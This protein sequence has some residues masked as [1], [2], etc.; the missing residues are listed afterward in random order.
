MRSIILT[1]AFIISFPIILIAQ[2]HQ[3]RGTVTDKLTGE[4]LQYV[5]VYIEQLSRGTV[6]DEK[7]GF[8][9]VIP[10]G[11]Y[12]IT[13]G[14]IGYKSETADVERQD[15]ILNILMIPVSHFLNEVNIYSNKENKGRVS[16]DELQSR[17]IEEYAGITKDAL[18]SVQLLPGVSTNNEATANFNVRGGSYDENLVLINGVHINEPFHL[19][20]IENASVGIFNIDMAKKVDFSAGGFGAENGD[21]LSSILKVDYREGNSDKFSAKMN[22]SM[23]DLGI[24]T[25]GY[26]DQ[27]STFIFGAR[28]SYLN[29]VLKLAGVK[30]LLGSTPIGL[31]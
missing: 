26:V 20:Q 17:Q 22:L 29:Q 5:N 9:L 16:S 2:S 30:G 23:V 12:K 21:A 10:D 4:G 6:T 19:K 7:G 14:H 13:F 1:A 28:R 8:L 31:Y 18:R 27:N 3:I 24:I 15:T 11:Q 25:E